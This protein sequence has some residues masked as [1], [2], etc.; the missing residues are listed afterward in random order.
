MHQS[1]PPGDDTKM[2][3]LTKVAD[4]FSSSIIESIKI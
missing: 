1:G 4:H 3:H 2:G